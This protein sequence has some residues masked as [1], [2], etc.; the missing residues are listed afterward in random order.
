MESKISKVLKWLQGGKPISAV[1]AVQMFGVVNLPS[2][3]FQ[4]RKRGYSVVTECVKD[5]YGRKCF[6][7]YKL[8]NN[9][10]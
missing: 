4:L 8:A 5:S 7:Q 10:K 3:I 2:V 9:D 1:L 6:N